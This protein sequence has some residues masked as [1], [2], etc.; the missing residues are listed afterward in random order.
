MTIRECIDAYRTLSKAVFDENPFDQFVNFAAGG[1]RFSGEKL[2]EA[3]KA[4]VQDP[5]RRVG[6]RMKDKGG[7][8]C[9]T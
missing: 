1:A 7:D 8:V 5:R 6:R 9:R 2:A 4:V 3:I